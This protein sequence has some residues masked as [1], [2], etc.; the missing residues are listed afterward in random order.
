MKYKQ[1]SN[2]G[3]TRIELLVIIVVGFL[4]L[5]LGVDNLYGV[6]RKKHLSICKYNLTQ[7]YRALNQFKND[8]EGDYPWNISNEKGGTSSFLSKYQWNYKHWLALKEYLKNPML[9]RC[10]TDN[11][12][13]A[14]SWS[15]EKPANSVK[16]DFVKFDNSAISY[17]IF[18]ESSAKNSVTAKSIISSDRNINFG[19]YNNDRD[20]KGAKKSLGKKFT[21]RNQVNWTQSMHHNNGILLL[22]DG[23]TPFVGHQGLMTELIYNN[24]T[25]NECL[26]PVGN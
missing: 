24:Y 8:S 18:S 10:S 25:K 3:F 17:T 26:F 1:K 9:L 7:F 14:S 2:K 12:D 13:S 20:K 23:S 19:K 15:Y 4:T 5:S 16:D 22:G 6:D 21:L 11:R